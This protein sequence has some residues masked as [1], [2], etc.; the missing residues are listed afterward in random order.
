MIEV[1]R[2]SECDVPRQV[3]DEHQWLDSGVIILKNDPHLRM[4]FAESENL[5][6]LFDVVEE[7][8]GI[9][10]E[11]LLIDIERKGTRDYFNPLIPR[12]VKDMLKSHAIG[13]DP[14]IDALIMT[15]R[16]N[17]LGNYDLVSY[18]YELDNDDYIT[19]VSYNAYSV[20]LALGDMAG[21]CEAVVEREYSKLSHK[22]VTA[23]VYEM[24]AAVSG[25]PVELRDRLERKEYHLRKGD[26]AL[27]RCTTCGC[28]SALHEFK[29]DLDRGTI[30][31]ALNG[32]RMSIVHPSVIDPVFEELEAELGEEIPH[33]VIEAQRQ[34]TRSG[35]FTIDEIADSTRFADHLALRGMGNL[36]EF[37][38]NAR[39]LRLELENVCMH[40]MV[41]GMV[42][43]LFEMSYGVESDIEWELTEEGDLRVEVTPEA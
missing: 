13:L 26:V 14:I 8:I 32:R 34:I 38:M 19:V 2:C 6:Y 3:A 23:G 28:P 9:P 43:G 31:S 35:F 5:D 41:A 37:E 42:Q 33:V 10:I 30:T 7:L 39:R 27:E 1:E 25:V 4:A 18:R 22:E 15:N 20:P 11:H 16:I 24:T 36:T 17:G 21:G 40:L 12:E 29:W